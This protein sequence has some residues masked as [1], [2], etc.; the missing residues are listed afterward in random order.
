MSIDD[1]IYFYINLENKG[2]SGKIHNRV[3][4]LTELKGLFLGEFVKF[5]KMIGES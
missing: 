2:V 3:S 4:Q 5:L 1:I